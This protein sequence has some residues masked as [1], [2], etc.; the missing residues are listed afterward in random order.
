MVGFFFIFHDFVLPISFHFY[1][2]S[3]L[4][5]YF[6]FRF[7]SISL[8]FFFFFLL[9]SCL[10]IYPIRATLK[11]IRAV[12]MITWKT[13]QKQQQQIEV[14]FAPFA[15]AKILLIAKKWNNLSFEFYDHVWFMQKVS[16]AERTLTHE[17]HV[18]KLPFALAHPI[19][20]N[21]NF[22]K[23]HSLCHFFHKPHKL[24]P[25]ETYSIGENQEF[26]F[27]QLY[28]AV[29]IFFFQFCLTTVKYWP[30][31]SIKFDTISIQG[32]NFLNNHVYFNYIN[33]HLC[34][35]CK[36]VV[37]KKEGRNNILKVSNISCSTS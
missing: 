8:F 29:I 35:Y 16:F 37:C 27:S 12:K 11:S 4:S 18:E 30:I 6:F 32:E 36:L 28:Y 34:F 7:V 10:T 25:I 20:L 22:E 26:F 15:H 2:F 3:F 24:P 21:W 23:L 31:G 33:S 14:G 1:S 19:P 17:K 13:L 9:F 5:Y